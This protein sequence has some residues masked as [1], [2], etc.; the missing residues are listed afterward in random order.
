M[1]TTPADLE[2]P[3]RVADW[4]RISDWA[5]M[6]AVLR[7]PEVIQ[8]WGREAP[9]GVPWFIERHLAELDGKEHLERRKMESQLFLPTALTIYEEQDVKPL[10]AEYVE[11]W[12]AQPQPDGTIR[13]DMAQEVF[14][15]LLRMAAR[16]AGIDGVDTDEQVA[17]VQHILDLDNR[18]R[19]GAMSALTVPE[20]EAVVQEAYATRQVFRE[21]YA[22]PSLARRRA[23][24]ERYQ[25]G[26]IAREDLPLD[27]I[28]IM[29][30]HWDE[31]WDDDLTMSEALMFIGGATGTT[32]RTV[33]NAFKRVTEWV[34]EHPEDRPLLEDDDFLRR[35]ID[36]TLRIDG[37]LPF[38]V[39]RTKGEVTLPSGTV[40]PPDTGIVLLINSGNRDPEIFGDDPDLF[41]PHRTA[42]GRV[43]GYGLAFGAGQH[44]CIGRRA[45]VGAEGIT[46]GNVMTILSTLLEE[47]AEFIPDDPPVRTRS[48]ILEYDHFPLRLAP[49]S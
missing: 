4:V 41:D 47:G 21:K 19:T 30:L 6:N 29:L 40:I 36:E 34:A 13:V 39:R 28:T 44:A 11:R 7:S 31:T 9:Y 46:R 20:H 32:K 49:L 37:V 42:A 18:M 33:C 17:E 2:L 8:G 38:L 5:D 16:V 24:F 23:L 22:G 27:V 14:K 10:I 26:E 25:A 35:A 12:R 3:E 48:Y 43:R 15:L 45:A 1:T